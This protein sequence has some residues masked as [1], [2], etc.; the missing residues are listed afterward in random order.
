VK[1]YEYTKKTD[2]VKKPILDAET[3]AATVELAGMRAAAYLGRAGEN[4]KPDKVEVFELPAVSQIAKGMENLPKIA[5]ISSIAH[6]NCPCRGI[7]IPI[8]HRRHFMAEAQ[9]AF[10]PRLST[11]M[12]Y[13]DGAVLRLMTTTMIPRMACRTIPTSWISTAA[14]ERPVFIGRGCHPAQFWKPQE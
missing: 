2:V 1:E 12:N 13:I 3:W 10:W 11:P 9:R 8:Q 6:G 4:M 14:R 7:T 5:Y